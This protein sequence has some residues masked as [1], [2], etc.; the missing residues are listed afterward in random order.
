MFIND[1][2]RNRIDAQ[3]VVLSQLF[4][5]FAED[6]VRSA[7]SVPAFVQ[8]FVGEDKSAILS[9]KSDELRYLEYNWTLNA[10]EGQ[11]VS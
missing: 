3:Q 2:M 6:F 1:P 10:Q 8:R 11:R 7:G 4:Q 5:W 9:T